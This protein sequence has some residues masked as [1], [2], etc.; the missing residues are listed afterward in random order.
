VVSDRTLAQTLPSLL[1]PT[2]SGSARADPCS[3]TKPAVSRTQPDLRLTAPS[4]EPRQWRG[5]TTGP[6]SDVAL[7]QI[8]RPA[9][10]R[11]G[12][13]NSHAMR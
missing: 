13:C 12:E 4:D 8:Q 6:R 7:R 5:G 10:Y 1:P 9:Q 3:S 11:G 2:A